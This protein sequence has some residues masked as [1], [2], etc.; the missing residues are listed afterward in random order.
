LL[1]RFTISGLLY[2]LQNQ[3]EMKPLGKPN[4]SARKHNQIP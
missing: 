3:Y 4:T 1:H 2:N